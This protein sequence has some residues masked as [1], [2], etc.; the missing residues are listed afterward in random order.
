MLAIS[1]TVSWLY[2]NIKNPSD[3]IHLLKNL[4]CEEVNSLFRE[5]KEILFVYL[6]K[7]Q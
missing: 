1:N 6:G 2:K 7:P 5:K 3:S 4:D